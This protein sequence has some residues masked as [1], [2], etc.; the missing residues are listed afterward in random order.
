MTM[1][2]MGLGN[3]IGAGQ[4]LE[5]EGVEDGGGCSWVLGRTYGEVQGEVM[6]VGDD[7]DDHDL[8][9]V[10]NHGPRLYQRVAK[11]E[12]PNQVANLQCY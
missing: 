5:L 8:E 2:R 3:C 9:W 1:V 7:E 10:V 4:A 12:R 6:T 11:S